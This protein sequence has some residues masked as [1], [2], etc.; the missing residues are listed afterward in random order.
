MKNITLYLFLN[1]LYVIAFA[2]KP[3]VVEISNAHS[4][5]D[6]SYYEAL[7]FN[8]QHVWFLGKHGVI[9]QLKDNQISSINYPSNGSNIL[10]AAQ[11]DKHHYIL[12]GDKGT[13]FFYDAINNKWTNLVLT[14]YK[15]SSL[16]SVWVINDKE[17]IICGGKSKIAR[18]EK[19]IP[20][21][22]IIRSEDG[23]KNWK[24]VYHSVFNMAWRINTNPTSHQLFVNLYHPNKSMLISSSDYGKT[25]KKT[26]IKSKG[27]IHDFFI[28][29]QHTLM[30]GGPNIKQRKQ[31]YAEFNKV[32]LILPDIGFIWDVNCANNTLVLACGKSYLAYKNLNEKEWKTIKLN[33]TENRNI[34][35]TVYVGNNTHYA[36]GSGKK[37]YKI[38]FE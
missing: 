2:Q 18:S 21:G 4:V 6:S 25:W 20:N 31:A 17:I 14:K 15:T 3:N 7:V 26:K 28:S 36:Y 24:R 12:T 16:Y 10:S 13:I 11:I 22:F 38:T 23:G 19:A 37:I 9:T 8:N 29:E 34:Y 5:C 35:K 32:P 27:I 30:V 1:L 33:E